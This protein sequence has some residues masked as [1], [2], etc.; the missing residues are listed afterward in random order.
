LDI[1]HHVI[2]AKGW[3]QPTGYKDAMVVLAEESLVSPELADRLQRWM[4]FRNA[5]VHFYLNIDHGRSFDA[6]V[7]DLR[8]LA[9]F[10]A[11]TARLLGEPP[12]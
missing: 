11:S 2:A 9:D 1:A 5:L 4:G 6:I 12:P 8:D 10:A 7:H 3:R